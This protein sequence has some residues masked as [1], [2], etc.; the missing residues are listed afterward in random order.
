MKILIIILI[1]LLIFFIIILSSGIYLYFN[2][3]KKLVKEFREFVLVTFNALKDRNIS[4]EE[5]EQILKE[6]SDLSPYAKEIK[7]KFISD[8]KNLGNDV[9]DL[10]YILKQKIK[11]K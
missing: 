9:R 1:V 2:I 11:N 7:D 4:D 5:R 6:M 8:S 10:Y 3:F